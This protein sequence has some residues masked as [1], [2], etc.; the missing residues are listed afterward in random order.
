MAQQTPSNLTNHPACK[1]S[2]PTAAPFDYI[3]IQY[4]VTGLSGGFL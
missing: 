1:H 3:V 4:T 2:R